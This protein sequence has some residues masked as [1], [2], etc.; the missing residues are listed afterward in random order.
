SPTADF[1]MNPNPALALQDVYFTDESVGNQLSSWVWSFGDGQ[2]GYGQSSTH[3]YNTGGVYTV[4]LSVTDINNCKDTATRLISVALLPVLP[5]GF[6]PNG[7]GEND[8]FIIRGGPFK[9]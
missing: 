7:D 8:S 1:T 2:N 9:T 3:G 5:T 6:S 4:T